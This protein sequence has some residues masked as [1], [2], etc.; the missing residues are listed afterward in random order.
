LA[1]VW[2][3]GFRWENRGVSG[4][5]GPQSCRRSMRVYQQGMYLSALD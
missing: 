4:G 3:D 1:L 2:N 5:A